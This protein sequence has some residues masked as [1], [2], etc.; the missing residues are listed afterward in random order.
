MNG[1]A[2]MHLNPV[3]K[4]MSADI[5]SAFQYVQSFFFSLRI[6][7]AYAFVVLEFFFLYFFVFC[8]L[9]PLSLAFHFLL[10]AC[11]LKL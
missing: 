8:C 4:N 2:L 7:L 3:L 9:V 6:L 5:C 10:S 11:F 1:F